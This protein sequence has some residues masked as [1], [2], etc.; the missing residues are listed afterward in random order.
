MHVE[1]RAPS[2]NRC[3]GTRAAELISLSVASTFNGCQEASSAEPI[4]SVPHDSGKLMVNSSA[5]AKEVVD[6]VS[7]V[8]SSSTHCSTICKLSS[9]SVRE[10]VF[11]S[12]ARKKER[13]SSGYSVVLRDV[14]LRSRS[15]KS[16]HRQHPRNQPACLSYWFP[17]MMWDIVE[18]HFH[19]KHVMLSIVFHGSRRDD[20]PKTCHLSV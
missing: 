13:S 12:L 5:S 19:P 16:S 2:F 10:R 17:Y 15:A 9:T 7:L 4:S 6:H 1:A 20:Y 3:Q 18:S 11:I 14:I 8:A